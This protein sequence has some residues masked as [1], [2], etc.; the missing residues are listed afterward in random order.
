ML[1]SYYFHKMLLKEIFVDPQNFQIW[2]ELIF[3]DAFIFYFLREFI[4]EDTRR[5]KGTLTQI[6]NH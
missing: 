6:M 2:S 1:V 3:S 4:F 5:R